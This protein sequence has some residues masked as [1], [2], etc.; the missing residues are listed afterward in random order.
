MDNHKFKMIPHRCGLQIKAIYD[1]LKSAEQ[2]AVNFLLENPQLI[3]SLSIVSYAERAGCSEATIVRLSRKLG[4]DGYLQLK[5]DFDTHHDDGHI[6]E[7]SNVSK[8]D[9][10]LAVLKKVFDVTVQGIEDTKN[11]LNEDVYLKVLESFCKANKLLF[12]GVGDAGA[13]A[14][15]AQQKFIRLGVSSLF[16]PDPDI[17]LILANQLRK[18]DVCV[19]ISHSGE[20]ES[21][22]KTVKVA[23][24]VGATIVLITNYPNSHLAKISDFLLQTAVFNTSITEEVISKRVTALCIIESVYVNY[25]IAKGA[26]TRRQLFSS[27]EIVGTNKL[28]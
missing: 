19:A 9:E 28:S 16:S 15:E 22:M 13:V 8:H 23:K 24:S 10:P 12:S 18:G 21:V 7:Y 11:M 5:K 1:D 27:N 17:Q 3:P 26:D 25:L 20:T 4:Y 6:K 2:K 14:M